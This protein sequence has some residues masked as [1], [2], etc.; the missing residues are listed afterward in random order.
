MKSL[1]TVIFCAAA[2]A[3]LILPAVAHAQFMNGTARLVSVTPVDGGCLYG[4]SG[5][6]VQLWDLEPGFTYTL[7]ISNVTECANGGTDPTLNVQ[8]RNGTTGNMNIVA[9][10]VSPGAYQFNVT[11]P[12]DAQCT[13][14]IIYC[15][16]PSPPVSAL[17]VIRNDGSPF[18]AHLR[19]STFGPGCTN[20]EEIYEWPYCGAVPAEN[21]TWGRVKSL[22]R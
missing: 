9:T 5:N 1:R 18:Q 4:P 19:A 3:L 6:Y 12:A 17:F 22:Y 15:I 8:V 2:C 11:M 10:Y 21:S 16:S 14:P 13:Y 20:P 7:T